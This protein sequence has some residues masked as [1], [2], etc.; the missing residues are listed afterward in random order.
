M[1]TQLYSV[2]DRVAKNFNFPFH[3]LNHDEAI[4]NFEHAL[5]QEPAVKFAPDYSLYYVGDFDSSTGGITAQTLE[6]LA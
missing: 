5:T 2:Y 1:K 6:C 4:R 3:C